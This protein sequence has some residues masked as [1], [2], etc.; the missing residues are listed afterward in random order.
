MPDEKK[1]KPV[2]TIFWAILGAF[3]LVFA[4]ALISN[5]FGERWGWAFYTLIFGFKSITS[6]FQFFKTGNKGILIG[7]LMYF[8][9][10]LFIGAI[11][12]GAWKSGRQI[13]FLFGF[14][15]LCFF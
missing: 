5:M 12:L 14:I 2:A 10:V 7:T 3:A 11:A 1:L 13:V 6:L 15:F 4:Y 9:N 8:S